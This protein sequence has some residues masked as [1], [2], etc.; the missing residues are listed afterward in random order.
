MIHRPLRLGVKLLPL[1]IFISSL[2]GIAHDPPLLRLGVKQ[3]PL[4]VFI[5]AFQ[6]THEGLLESS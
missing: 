1:S 5:D 3:L 2:V 4:N 6:I